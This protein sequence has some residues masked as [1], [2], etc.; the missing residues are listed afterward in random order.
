MLMPLRGFARAGLGGDGLAVVLDEADTVLVLEQLAKLELMPEIRFPFAFLN[1]TTPL[2][3]LTSLLRPFLGGP[4]GTGWVELEGLPVSGLLWGVEAHPEA[5]VRT[6]LGED[7]TGLPW[8]E[9]RSSLKKRG[10]P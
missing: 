10:S 4:M 2:S 9:L 7:G 3:T 6:V 5:G 8:T 1:P